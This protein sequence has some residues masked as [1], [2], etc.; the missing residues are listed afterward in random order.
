MGYLKRYS[1]SLWRGQGQEAKRGEAGGH[2][3]TRHCEAIASFFLPCPTTELSLIAV[4]CLIGAT[5]WGAAV[6]AC[7]DVSAEARRAERVSDGG[8]VDVPRAVSGSPRA[9]RIT[10]QRIA[11]C[12]LYYTRNCLLPKKL[13]RDI[14]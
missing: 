7:C 1:I 10:A 6:D 11:R 13:R 9:P 12:D 3:I 8:V 5:P 14:Q 2:R 4:W